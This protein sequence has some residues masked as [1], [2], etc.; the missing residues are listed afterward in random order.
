MSDFTNI[1]WCDATLNIWWGCTKV[2]DG[3]KFCY[4][5]HLA[6]HRHKKGNWGPTGTRR[7]VKS[8]RSTLEKISKRA[9][10]ENRRLKVFCQSMSDT[11]EGP[12]TMGGVG[13]ENWM[14]VSLLRDQLLGAI[15]NYPHLDFLLLTKRP[16]NVLR[17]IAAYETFIHEWVGNYD[18]QW[19]W[20]TNLWI[21]TSVEDQKTADERIPHLLTIPASVR[22]LSCEPLLGPVTLP[23][24]TNREAH[25]EAAGMGIEP[26]FFRI[27]GIN[28]DERTGNG[29]HWVI[30]GAESGP[31][32]RPMNPDWARS[33]RNQCVAAGV[34]FFF[35]QW[36]EWMPSDHFR[37]YDKDCQRWSATDGLGCCITEAPGFTQIRDDMFR[38]GKKRAGRILDGREWNEYP[39]GV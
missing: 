26:M 28:P 2:S 14:T 5:E 33:L 3:C 4:A 19:S 7:E 36:G 13:S 8:W 12:E 23:F 22:F 38:V 27:S 20:P 31:N 24:P 15:G 18:Y 30:V 10:A 39:E 37:K 11:F 1:E 6:D 17:C 9:K 34:A 21:G 32:A 25:E 16:E 35:K 29:I